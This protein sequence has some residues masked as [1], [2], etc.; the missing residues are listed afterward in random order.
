MQIIFGLDHDDVTYRISYFNLQAEFGIRAQA[1]QHAGSESDQWLLHE[2]ER[3]FRDPDVLDAAPAEHTSI[4]EI[5]GNKIFFHGAGIIRYRWLSNNV[6]VNIQYSVISG[7]KPEPLE[8]IQ[9]YLAKHPSTITLNNA[10]FQSTTH[11]EQWI[12]DEMAG[13]C[14]W[15][16]NGFYKSK[17]ARPRKT[18]H[19][20]RLLTT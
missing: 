4:R 12:K 7:D 19:F 5:N 6:F 11:S 2:V 18:K 15:G 20:E 8:I 14:G 13:V 3:G 9:A 17:P 10:E 16:I 1:T